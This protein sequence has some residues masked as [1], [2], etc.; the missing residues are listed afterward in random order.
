MTAYGKVFI[1]YNPKSTGNGRANAK[2]VASKLKNNSIEVTLCA[3]THA[4]HA[5]ELA[6]DL[7]N[8]HYNPLL[9][10]ASG[11]GGY[12]EVIN[13]ALR[14]QEE[15][16]TKPVCA[17]LASGNANDHA[18]ALQKN[19]E[20]FIEH[21]LQEKVRHVDVLMLASSKNIR[22]AHS[23]IGI[24]ITPAIGNELNKKDLNT[25]REIWIALSE[26]SKAKPTAL[27]VN[28]KQRSFN[29]LVFAN[30]ARMA[31]YIKTTEEEL[32][33]DGK[34]E[35]IPIVHHNKFHF[36][37]KLLETFILKPN[38]QHRAKSYTFTTTQKT[39]TQLD[40]EIITIDKNSDVTIQSLK[41]RLATIY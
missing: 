38:V 28:N 24:G 22:Y 6:Y 41:R 9:I 25:L 27:L 37:R 7:A 18:S 36:F 4:G 1:I 13:G 11:D 2:K 10:S 30:T 40:G 16:S 26:I 17:V 23:Y 19:V 12:N 15:K 21:I 34:F 29:S 32:P 3:T 35:V 14:S 31:K 39:K 20:S 8:K 33:N 5:E